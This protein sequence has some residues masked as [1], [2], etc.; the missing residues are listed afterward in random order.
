[1]VSHFFSWQK[2]PEEMWNHFAAEFRDKGADKLVL[3]HHWTSRLVEE[4]VFF[5]RIKEWSKVNGISFVGAHAPFGI[6]WDMTTVK[7]E[8]LKKHEK[9]IHYLSLL[10]IKSC[11]YHVGLLQGSLEESREH[12]LSALKRIVACG[13][14]HGVLI[15]IENAEHSGG[16][17]EELLFYRSKINSPAL[18]FCFDSGHA[19]VNGGV[20]FVLEKLIDDI[21]VCH[22]HDNGGKG[23]NHGVPGTGTIPWKSVIKLL[24]KA[25]RL[26]GLEN[27]SNVL[28]SKYSYTEVIKW[29]DCFDR[30]IFND[31]K[32]LRGN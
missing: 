18:G 17:Y 23:D 21:V 26:I 32:N 13:E 14:K 5:E 30:E 8:N 7:E 29:F 16:S 9:I 22:I 12:A 15:A 2:F 25:P 1:M 24:Q 28:C 19:N 3:F 11:T 10:G 27:E 4:N 6:N 20:I 31:T